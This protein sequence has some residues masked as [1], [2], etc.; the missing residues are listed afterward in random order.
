[1]SGNRGRSLGRIYQ[2]I[3]ELLC[4]ELESTE[5][6]EQTDDQQASLKGVKTGSRDVELA[7]AWGGRG[8]SDRASCEN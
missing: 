8:G 4:S 3:D 5:E 6:R 1:M 7:W 2:G